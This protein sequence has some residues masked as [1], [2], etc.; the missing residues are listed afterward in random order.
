MSTKYSR[1][2]QASKARTVLLRFLCLWRRLRDSLWLFAVPFVFRR[3]RFGVVLRFLRILC[4]ASASA[5]YL[6][7]TFVGIIL[8]DCIVGIRIVLVRTCTSEPTR[9]TLRAEEYGLSIKCPDEEIWTYEDLDAWSSSLA[10]LLR[11]GLSADCI[12]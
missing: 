8:I 1:G 11:P 2:H 6:A 4:R 3:I 7:I 10:P 5:W 9:S 12:L